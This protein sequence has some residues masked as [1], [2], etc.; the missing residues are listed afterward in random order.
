MSTL[1]TWL[2]SCAL[3][4]IGGVALATATDGFRAFTSEAAR[5]VEIRR[6]PPQVPAVTLETQSGAHVDVADLRGKSDADVIAAMLNVTDSRFQTELKLQAKDAGKL[7]RDYQIPAVH[8]E[9]F[10]ERIA[11]ALKPARDAGLLPAFPFGCD[12][13]DVE[14]RL[15]PALQILQDASRSPRQLLSLVL[16]GLRPASMADQPALA[17]MGL[18]RPNML[19]DRFY[20]VLL[21]AALKRSD[22]K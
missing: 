2:A 11:A 9:N 14:Q 8:R 10:P 19:S 17:R 16:E 20:R 18:D 13:T 3:L 15:I 7:P 4:V 22:K 1:R 5:R 21:N 6:H 12:F